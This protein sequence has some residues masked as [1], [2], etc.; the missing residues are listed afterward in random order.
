MSAARSFDT[1]EDAYRR[2]VAHGIE[3]A[4]RVLWDS[5]PSWHREEFERLQRNSTQL[6]HS[7]H[8][9][10]EYLDTLVLMQGMIG[11]AKA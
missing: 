1:T 9:H 4:R 11:K 7:D 5:L 6:R 2:G 8:P 10:T 3:A